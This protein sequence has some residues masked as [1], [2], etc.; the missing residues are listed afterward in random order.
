MPFAGESA[1]VSNQA[2]DDFQRKR[3]PRMICDT[4]GAAC[5]QF[6]TL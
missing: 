5:E 1:K 3:I 2:L 4:I 6:G